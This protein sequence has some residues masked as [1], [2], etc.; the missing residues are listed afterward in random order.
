M[1]TQSKG[2]YSRDCEAII[3]QGLVPVGLGLGAT[4]LLIGTA[5]ATGGIGVVPLAIAMGLLG[6]GSASLFGTWAAG[7]LIWRN[8]SQEVQ[9]QQ[10]SEKLRNKMYDI[11][12]ALQNPLAEWANNR[13]REMFG[14]G[15]AAQ[16][17]Q[18]TR[19]F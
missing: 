4:G 18:F 19:A 5:I 15:F 8:T 12:P 10:R 17:P 13:R 9:R 1:E 3:G 14:Q 11:L 7:K 16:A 6:A 2:R